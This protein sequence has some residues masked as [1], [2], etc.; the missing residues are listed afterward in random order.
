MLDSR[1]LS[2]VPESFARP[3]LACGLSAPSSPHFAAAA[4]A[5]RPL[6]RLLASTAYKWFS[7][8]LS[9]W[10]SSRVQGGRCYVQDLD[11][12]RAPR[13]CESYLSRGLAQLRRRRRECTALEL[14]TRHRREDPLYDERTRPSLAHK[15]ARPARRRNSKHIPPLPRESVT[16]IAA[17]RITPPQP[18]S[19]T[20]AV[21]HSLS[22]PQPQSSMAIADASAGP[23]CRGCGAGRGGG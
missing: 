10:R 9:P 4:S 20:A 12:L 7:P 23:S 2:A 21:L 11:P 6:R 22:P 18:Q 5:A 17:M 16:G 1:G 3:Y 13:G 8:L 19:S 14:R 15:S